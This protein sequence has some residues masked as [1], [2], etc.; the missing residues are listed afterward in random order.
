M[1]TETS[2]S[3]TRAEWCE[4]LERR[5]ACFSPVLTLAE[6]PAHG[7]HAARGTYSDVDGVLQP[8]PAPR[9]DRT[10]PAP[11]PPV[12]LEKTASA[13]VLAGWKKT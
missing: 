1:F 2:P 7:H 11:A 6:S 5:E 12:P 10:P 13:D 8:A 9:F 4:A 3:R